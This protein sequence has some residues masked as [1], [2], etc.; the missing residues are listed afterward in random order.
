MLANR[1]GRGAPGAARRGAP[2]A[3]AAA[4]HHATDAYMAEMYRNLE[5]AGV[6]TSDDAHRPSFVPESSAPS[7][8]HL[9]AR[10]PTPIFVAPSSQWA[11]G[12]IDP[13]G[14]VATVSERNLFCSL[15]FIMM[16]KAK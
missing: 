14:R 10:G 16:T 6:D 15:L 2:A 4:S 3:S 12:P 1:A 9:G 5:L 13:A 11:S 7:S 8:L